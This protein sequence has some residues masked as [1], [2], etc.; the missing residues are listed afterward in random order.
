M[1]TPATPNPFDPTTD[2]VSNVIDVPVGESGS[3]TS[4]GSV[5]F[6]KSDGT[7]VIVF[8]T[9]ELALKALNYMNSNNLYYILADEDITIINLQVKLLILENTFI[10]QKLL[11]TY[12]LTYHSN[13]V[14]AIHRSISKMATLKDALVSCGYKTELVNFL[15]NSD[16]ASEPLNRSPFVLVVDWWYFDTG[17]RLQDTSQI[18][19][20]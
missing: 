17:S 7:T 5:N 14:I 13:E 10:N 20:Q 9:I 6:T 11:N 12:T 15:Q 16:W 2:F 18:I 8:E 1:P 19:F 4:S 3:P